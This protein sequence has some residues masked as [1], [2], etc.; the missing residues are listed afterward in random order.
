MLFL[1][2]RA[3]PVAARGATFKSIRDFLLRM[4]RNK[5]SIGSAI[6]VD[7]ALKVLRF[8][9]SDFSYALPRNG[10]KR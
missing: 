3:S 4:V 5:D 8:G 10:R 7:A 9:R 6:A 1:S 2:K